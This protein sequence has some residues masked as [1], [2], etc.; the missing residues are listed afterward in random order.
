MARV[1]EPLLLEIPATAELMPMAAEA[2]RALLLADRPAEAMSWLR[3][4]GDAE[5]RGALALIALAA[6]PDQDPRSR[7]TRAA[8]ELPPPGGDDAA[9]KRRRAVLVTLLPALGQPVPTSALLSLG[10][11]SAVALSP[12]AL[13]LS[14]SSAGRRLGES[15]LLSFA[16]IG[17]DGPAAS[18]VAVARVVE[19][20]R[21]VG[22][23]REAGRLAIEAAVA[24]DL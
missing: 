8:G 18:P 23:Q 6:H 7:E 11:G 9:A 21:A 1:V 4:A 16:L 19:A 24:A 13:A 15:L 3:V 5:Q 17:G 20:L 2:A 12:L 22:L 10:E 14:S